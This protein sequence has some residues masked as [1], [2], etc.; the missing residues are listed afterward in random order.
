MASSLVTVAQ[1]RAVPVT[2]S[3]FFWPSFTSAAARS[4]RP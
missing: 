3:V 4:L 2:V 1:L